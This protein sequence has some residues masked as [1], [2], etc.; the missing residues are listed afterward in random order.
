[1]KLQ[2]MER[3]LIDLGLNQLKDLLYNI[4]FV[5]YIEARSDM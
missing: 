5:K 4:P 2:Y 1:M 3:Q